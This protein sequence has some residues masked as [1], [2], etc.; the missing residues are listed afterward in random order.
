MDNPSRISSDGQDQDSTEES[1]R[2]FF[3]KLGSRMARPRGEAPAAIEAL[4]DGR[5]GSPRLSDHDGF[6][7]TYELSWKASDTRRPGCSPI[8]GALG[9]GR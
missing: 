4:F 2:G 6:L 3:G 5:P 9:A 7:V 8:P 1:G